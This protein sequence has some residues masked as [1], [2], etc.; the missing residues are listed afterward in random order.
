METPQFAWEWV[1]ETS[2]TGGVLRVRGGATNA[3]EQQWL[4]AIQR[5]DIVLRDPSGDTVERVLLYPTF[6][7][8][9]TPSGERSSLLL[10]AEAR[11]QRSAAD[12]PAV[13]VAEYS[14]QTPFGELRGEALLQRQHSAGALLLMPMVEH[15]DSALLCRLRVRR[16]RAVPGEY[17]PSSER[18]RLE[19][20]AGARR[21]WSSADGMAFLQVIGPVEPTEIGTESTYEYRWDGRL[22]SGERLPAGKYTLRL[23]LPARPYEYAVM[24]PLR[25]TGKP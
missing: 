7:G 2:D 4:R 10:Q 9:S 19:L 14:A 21:I 11:L 18:L 5:F 23:S 12:I 24:V 16:V 20:F 17:F 22:P 15:S 1:L 25:W 8:T 13:V 6:G 3:H